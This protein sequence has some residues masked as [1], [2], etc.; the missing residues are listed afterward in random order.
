MYAEWVEIEIDKSVVIRV[1]VSCTPKTS[2][3]EKRRRAIGLASTAFARAEESR[4]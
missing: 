3:E 4:L 2:E 1:F